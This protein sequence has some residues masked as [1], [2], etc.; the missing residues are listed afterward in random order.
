[1]IVVTLRNATLQ[2]TARW[3]IFSASGPIAG[4]RIARQ[5]ERVAEW[6]MAKKR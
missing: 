1:M 4:E 5:L 6:F 2:E 3:L